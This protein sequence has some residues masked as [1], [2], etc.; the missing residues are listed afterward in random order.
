MV[1]VTVICEGQS[2]EQF[3]K[4]LVALP[5][6]HDWIACLNMTMYNNYSVVFYPGWLK[7]S[8]IKNNLKA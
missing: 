6:V 4:Q 7:N 2:E 1:E 5:A 8:S 3:I